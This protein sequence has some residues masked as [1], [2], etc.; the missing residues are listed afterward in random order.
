MKTAAI[1][2]KKLNRYEIKISSTDVMVNTSRCEIG[3]P[4][5]LI[6]GK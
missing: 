6:R 4:W 1:A 5:F 3:A 2:S